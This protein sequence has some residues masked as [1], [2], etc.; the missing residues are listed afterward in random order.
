M[1]C[2]DSFVLNAISQVCDVG[3]LDAM[4]AGLLYS[5]EAKPRT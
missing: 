2:C 4:V 1:E 5:K 3:I